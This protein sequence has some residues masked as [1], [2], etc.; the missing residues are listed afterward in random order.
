MEAGIL[1]KQSSCS[2]TL[3]DCGAGDYKDLTSKT[4]KYKRYNYRII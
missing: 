4:E 3:K 2:T 1:G